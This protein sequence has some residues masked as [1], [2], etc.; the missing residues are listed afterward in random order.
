MNIV[1]IASGNPAFSTLV[2]AVT[3][4]GLADAL[5]GKGPYTVLAPSNDAFA[6]LDPGAV[7]ALLQPANRPALEGVL[8]LHVIEGRHPTGAWAGQTLK[9]TTLGGAQV[10]VRSTPDGV[11]VDGARIVGHPIE[12]SN[13]LI[14]VIDHV[15]ASP[16]ND[17]ERP[18]PA[19]L[20]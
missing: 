6:R 5:A 12:A 2:R 16:S 11:H 13:G 19:E 7:A 9:V 10:T 3:A 18:A 14:H 15:L 1:E 17:A 8:K 20:T 4:A